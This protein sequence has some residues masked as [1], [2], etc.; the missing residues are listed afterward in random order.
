M[1]LQ[2]IICSKCRGI[3]VI[4]TNSNQTTSQIVYHCLRCGRKFIMCAGG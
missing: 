2:Q 4:D 1:I 3:V